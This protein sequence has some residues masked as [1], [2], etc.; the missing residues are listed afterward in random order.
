MK[1]RKIA[2][3]LSFKPSSW[4]LG[5]PQSGMFFSSVC[6]RHGVALI[7]LALMQEAQEFAYLGKW[8][9]GMVLLC[10]DLLTI[11]MY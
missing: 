8:F 1:H 2:P 4:S 7:L 9:I 3:S 11:A 6:P 5:L 10:A